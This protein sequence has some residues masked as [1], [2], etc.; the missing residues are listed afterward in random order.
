MKPYFNCH[1][2]DSI[3]YCAHIPFVYTYSYISSKLR[4]GGG[5]YSLKHVRKFCP[6]V[7]LLFKGLNT[8]ISSG[9]DKVL[10]EVQVLKKFS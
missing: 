7:G 8:T 10:C 9:F 1:T 5:G 4:R 3:N 6:F 2:I